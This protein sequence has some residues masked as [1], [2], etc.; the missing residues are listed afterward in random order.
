MRLHLPPKPRAVQSRS[1]ETNNH[2][3]EPSAAYPFYAPCESQ[4]TGGFLGLFTTTVPG[5]NHVSLVNSPAGRTYGVANCDAWLHET[6]LSTLAAAGASNRTDL[7]RQTLPYRPEWGALAWISAEPAGG[8]DWGSLLVGGNALE[9]ETFVRAARLGLEAGLADGQRMVL[10]DRDTADG[11]IFFGIIASP[12]AFL[13]L[14]ATV[15]V[16][17]VVVEKGAE[18]ARS[19]WQNRPALPTF[20]PT[21]PTFRLPFQ[22]STAAPRVRLEQPPVEMEDIFVAAPLDDSDASELSES[23]VWDATMPAEWNSPAP[24]GRASL[25]SAPE[26][27]ENGTAALVREMDALTQEPPTWL[28]RTLVSLGVRSDA[29]PMPAGYKGRSNA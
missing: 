18:A 4:E 24:S 27:I 28:G 8:H 14:G 3:A 15:V 16:G 7:S 13:L 23:A 21:L 22:R 9:D 6:Y 5:N 11:W 26:D 25:E 1:N 2:E 19:A 10:A 17:K 29:D 20:R 12:L